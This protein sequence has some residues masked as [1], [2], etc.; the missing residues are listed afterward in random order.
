MAFCSSCG[1]NLDGQAVCPNCGTPAGQTIMV[2]G[3][4]SVIQGAPKVSGLWRSQR[5]MM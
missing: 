4:T 1:T 5:W 2:S 3:N